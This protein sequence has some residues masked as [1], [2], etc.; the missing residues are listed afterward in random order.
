[1]DD[2][3]NI[4]ETFTELAPRYEEVVDSEISL[5]WG[6]GYK[7]FVSHYLENIPINDGDIV[8]DV[9]T[10][11]GEIPLNLKQKGISQNQI[12]GLDITY[13]MLERAKLRLTGNPEPCRVRLACASAMAMPYT[14]QSFN[15]I[16]CAL[17]THH[18]DVEKLVHEM[19]RVLENGGRLSIADVGA[20]GFW[21]LPGIKSLLRLFAFIFFL[22]RENLNRAWAEAGAISN[23]RSIEEW[24]EILLNIGFREIKFTKL[25]S[26]HFWIPEPHI[27]SAIKKQERKND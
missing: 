13:S 3:T 18:M 5:F 15:L 14:D 2:Q 6:W 12:H 19:Y 8:L 10:G 7:K 1:M 4:I 23:V 21:V 26:K 27:I 9:A 24:N 22:F 16:T 25:K 20:S 17:A 11:T